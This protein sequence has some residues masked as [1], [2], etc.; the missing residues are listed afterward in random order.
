M[1]KKLILVFV[2]IIFFS[3]FH[4]AFAGLVINEIMY[5]LSGSDSTNSKSREWIEIYNSDSSEISIDASK[6][7]IYDGGSNRTIN[8]EVNFSIPALAYIILAG[9]KD[10]FLT[11]HVGYSGVVYDTGITSLNNTGATLK[12]LDQD[13]NVVDTAIYASSTGGAGDGNSLQLISGSWAGATSTPGIA[14]EAVVTPPPS[15]GV[16]SSSSSAP[17]V[18]VEVQKIKTQIT[19]K[20]LGFVGLPLF[21]QA[22]TLGHS[23]EQLSSGKY[24]W[25]FG[26]GDSRET[27]VINGQQFTHSYFYPGEYEVSLFYYSNPYMY[28]D[29]PDARDQITIKI[30][31]ADISISRVGDDKDFFVELTNNT[32]YNADL[33]NWSLISEKKSFTIPRNT[34]LATK[35]KIIISSKITNFSIEDKNTLKLIN[36]QGEVVF[37]Y[38]ASV[39]P[40][41]PK[42][43]VFPQNAIS[44]NINTSDSVA[45]I[46]KDKQIPVKDLQAS[47]LS[48]GILEQEEKSSYSSSV[49]PIASIVL[50]GT[51]AG[52]VYFIRRR[53]TV[54]KAG[55]D[56]E[57][58]D[59]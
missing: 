13:G 19:S 3:G 42:I 27:G 14:N 36:S 26:D 50:I 51:S 39:A 11:D 6:W 24:F 48:S 54:L 58:L 44:N 1:S 2:G 4:F 53:K 37:D 21:F 29:I 43:N 55:D 33:S 22:T 49:I 25:N 31:G 15:S 7:R 56:F 57:I 9:D 35:K 12:I 30:I 45:L 59:E 16:S 34:I 41:L 46:N 32:D 40:A 10:T 52:A 8:G 5:D 20:T 18:V 17:T 38:S 23:G 47:V 28:Q